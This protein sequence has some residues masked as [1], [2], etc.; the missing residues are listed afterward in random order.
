MKLIKDEASAW[1]TYRVAEF[2]L[3]GI[4]KIDRGAWYIFRQWGGERIYLRQWSDAY[5]RGVSKSLALS[6]LREEIKKHRESI[7]EAKG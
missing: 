7:I 2:P 6:T 1:E 4:E 5:G 3:W